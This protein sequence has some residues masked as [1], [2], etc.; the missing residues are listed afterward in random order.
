MG[1]N[2]R[3]ADVQWLDD[4][5]QAAWWALLEVGSGLFDALSADLRRIA[6]LT[7]EDYE[8]LHLLSSQEHH[9]LRIGRLADEMLS[10]RTRL[11]QRID[12]LT[13]R[14][15]VGRERCPS[16]GR[17]INVVLTDRGHALLV[18]IAPRHLESVRHHV[19]DQLDP[20]DVTAMATGLG[21]VAEHLHALRAGEKPA[22]C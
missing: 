4:D 14:G 7:L 21:K 3:E 9:R 11:S 10:S 12:R 16:D 8:V 19:F 20:D 6:D 5:E 22:G 15:L 18:D 1:N 2:G 13:E 17:A